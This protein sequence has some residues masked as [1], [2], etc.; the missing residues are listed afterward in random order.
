MELK[1]AITEINTLQYVGE[2][3]LI[4]DLDNVTFYLFLAKYLYTYLQHHEF[5]GFSCQSV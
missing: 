1:Y 5:Q 2:Q 3:A 4:S